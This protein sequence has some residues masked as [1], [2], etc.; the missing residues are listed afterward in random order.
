MSE[1]NKLKQRIDRL[2]EQVENK[3]IRDL[4]GKIP[5]PLVCSKCGDRITRY[6]WCK[7]GSLDPLCGKCAAEGEPDPKDKAEI[8]AADGPD[9]RRM[10]PREAAKLPHS[11]ELYILQNSNLNWLKKIINKIKRRKMIE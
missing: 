7:D 5:R 10:T 8:L 1:L 4:L 11:P 6:I 9:V 3:E 2:E